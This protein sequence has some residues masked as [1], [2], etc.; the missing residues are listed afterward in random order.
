MF[1]KEKEGNR[2]GKRD[3]LT[4]TKNVIPK[5]VYQIY[6]TTFRNP[7]QRKVFLGRW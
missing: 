3:E 2:I 7:F 6:I 1:K 5:R 4:E